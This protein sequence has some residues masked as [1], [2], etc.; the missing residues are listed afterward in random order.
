M[1]AVMPKKACKCV[2][3][4]HGPFF[5]LKDKQNYIAMLLFKGIYS[6]TWKT[7][8]GFVFFLSSLGFICMVDV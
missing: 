4:G 2:F 6:I 8:L 3:S 1:I 7:A 5:N